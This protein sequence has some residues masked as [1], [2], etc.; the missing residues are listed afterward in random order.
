[1]P[2][3]APGGRK[4]VPDST[5]SAP[6][7]EPAQSCATADVIQEAV[8][9]GTTKAKT[10]NSGVS[11]RKRETGEAQ[12]SPL[13]GKSTVTS[14]KIKVEGAVEL[15]SATEA[16]SKR[17]EQ[18]T[19]GEVKREEEVIEEITLKNTQAPARTKRKPSTNSAA[20][21][22]EEEELEEAVEETTPK[23]AKRKRK[24]KEEKEAE[25]MPIAARTAGLRMFVGA[26]VSGAKGRHKCSIERL[27]AVYSFHRAKS[28]SL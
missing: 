10:R 9:F 25:A 7:P 18:S 1:M 16:K 11:K 2:S 19:E 12:P 14:K 21:K 20:V 3:K 6:L 4:A 5:G 17:G 22:V 23:K 8:S 28:E 27:G 13:K 26:H 24:T 15:G